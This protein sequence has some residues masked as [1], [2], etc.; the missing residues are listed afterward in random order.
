M[1]QLVW[2]IFV[3]L[4]QMV[5]LSLSRIEPT[6]KQRRS[7]TLDQNLARFSTEPESS[8]W[9]SA[10]NNTD[11]L[12]FFYSAILPTESQLKNNK[13]WKIWNH[14]NI[15]TA[16]NFGN[17]TKKTVLLASYFQDHCSQ[18][19]LLRIQ[20]CEFFP[21]DTWLQITLINW[22]LPGTLDSGICSR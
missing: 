10:T 9:S 6:S 4:T 13:N 22:P 8:R 1:A 20:N 5:C 11:M 15:S 17:Q 14:I 12:C 2:I 19:L 21:E 16:Q 18:W 3:S 7:T